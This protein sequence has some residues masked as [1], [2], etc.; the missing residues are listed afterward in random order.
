MFLKVWGLG[1]LER[2]AKVI[3]YKSGMGRQSDQGWRV[4]ELYATKNNYISDQS[5]LPEL[6]L[7][8]HYWW[9]LS[10]SWSRPCWNDLSLQSQNI[11]RIWV[12]RLLQSSTWDVLR[13]LPTPGPLQYTTSSLPSSCSSLASTLTLLFLSMWVKRPQCFN[14]LTWLIICRGSTDTM[15]RSTRNQSVKT[16]NLWYMFSPTG[17]S[18]RNASRSLSI[19]SLSSLWRCHCSQQFYRVMSTLFKTNFHRNFCYNKYNIRYWSSP[20]KLLH[21]CRVL[22]ITH[23]FSHIQPRR[24]SRQHFVFLRDL[25]KTGEHRQTQT[26]TTTRPLNY[27]YRFIIR[28]SP[29]WLKKCDL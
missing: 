13:Y 29:Y 6:H 12:V 10:L 23:L 25:G 22:H 3:C 14:L 5:Q 8:C 24:C 17:I 2:K 27:P 15:S 7:F 9:N 18:S 11:F 28:I 4:L 19:F 20:P 21:L 26:D 16:R 1:S